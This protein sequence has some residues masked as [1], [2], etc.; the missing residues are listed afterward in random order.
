MKFESFVAHCSVSRETFEK[1]E[2]YARELVAWNTKINLVGPDTVQ[3]LWERHILDALQLLT[4]LKSAKK[5][6]DLGSGAGLPGLVIA[7]AS[8]FNVSLVE[9][10]QKK[11]AFLRHIK[12]LLGLDVSIQAVRIENVTAKFD[13]I[14]A[15]A[16]APLDTLLSY[17][18]P[19]LEAGG[20]CVFLKGE[21]YENEV[22]E[23]EKKWHFNISVYPSLTHKSGAIIELSEVKRNGED[24]G[25]S[26]IKPK[27]RRR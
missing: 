26:N 11:V 22:E 1:L 16:L 19:L 18:E 20:R 6:V 9:S 27:G 25:H 21:S 13:V 12:G 8:D 14:T 24:K 7:I 2:I 3:N 4:F 17:A 23:A 5:I 10:D 15:R